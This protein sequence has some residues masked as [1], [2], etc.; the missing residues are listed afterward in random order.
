MIDFTYRNLTTEGYYS[1]EI[2]INAI[3]EKAREF[4]KGS[5][6]TLN[7]VEGVEWVQKMEAAGLRSEKLPTITI[8]WSN[9]EE[10]ADDFD[11]DDWS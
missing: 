1:T 6:I 3:T 9:A 8:D 5:G 11:E 4:I 2:E 7:S 10:D